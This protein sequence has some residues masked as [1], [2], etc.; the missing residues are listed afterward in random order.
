[1]QEPATPATVEA[2]P[3]TAPST[4]EEPA[5][6]AATA[7]PRGHV[8]LLAPPSLATHQLAKHLPEFHRRFPKITLE[9]HAPGPVDTNFLFD[10]FIG[11]L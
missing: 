11:L 10:Q 6:G 4:A 8:R 5:E 9:I 1:M 7:E 3:A 2:A